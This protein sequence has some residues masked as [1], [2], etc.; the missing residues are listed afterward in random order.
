[1]E[2]RG[3]SN[4]L[5]CATQLVALLAASAAMGQQGGAPPAAPGPSVAQTAANS[6]A[7]EKPPLKQEELDQML[8]PLALYPDSL[9]SQVFMAATYPLEVVSADRWVKQNAS[10]KGDAMAAA[11]EKQAWDPSVKSLVNFPQVLAMMSEKLDMTVKLG[12]AFIGQQKQ[13]MD[14]VQKLRAKA[15]AQGNLKSTKEQTVKTEAAA[16]GQVIVIE[17]ADPQVIYVPTYSPTVVYG[18]W[19]YPAYPPYPYYPPGYVA[20]TAALAFGVGVAC[21]LAWG[22]AWGGCNWGHG[23]VD[24]DVN[25]NV[26]I[27]NTHIDRSKAKADLR[28]RGGTAA[29]GG[30]GAWKH[31]PSHRQGVPYRDQ[32]TAQ[33]V[34]GAS[35]MDNAARARDSYRGRAETGRQDINRGAADQ[36]RGGTPG[37]N[38]TRDRAGSPN[39]GG[40]TA[41][42]G[43]PDRSGG[44]DRAGSSR[45]GGAF[46]GVSGGGHEARSASQRGNAS[47]SASPGRSAPSRGGGR[48]GR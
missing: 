33:R 8:A 7:T 26:N 35:S 2:A 16:Q 44:S 22:Y 28:Q 21:G 47:R 39:A 3:F 45:R 46:D 4:R 24:I 40:A 27:N 23:D 29:G 48:R 18:P 12:D 13:V 43:A 14:S 10:L 6:G 30:A 25:R 37:G 31:D 1:M 38:A 15:Q 5:V 41:R 36:F 11:L 20:G 42:S 17:P 19:P 9:L 34:G 32:S